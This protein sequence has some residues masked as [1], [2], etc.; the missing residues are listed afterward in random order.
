[1]I[2][3]ILDCR[4]ED[5]NSLSDSLSP[6]LSIQYVFTA[7]ELPA[8]F[9]IPQHLEM[10]FLP[11]PPKQLFFCCLEA[12]TSLGGE[13]C[14]SDF[15]AVYDQLDQDIRKEFEDKGVS[16]YMYIYNMYIYTLV[17]AVKSH[18]LKMFPGKFP[19]GAVHSPC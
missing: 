11:S 16:V 7:S 17:A 19:T 6:L 10:S 5:T 1:M 15:K 2:S 9:P 18:V 4:D 8:F 14:L 12:P 3:F 13:T